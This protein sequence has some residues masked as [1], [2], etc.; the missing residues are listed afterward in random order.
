[1]GNG[2]NWTRLSLNRFST[3]PSAEPEQKVDVAVDGN[4]KMRPIPIATHQR[5]GPDE[6]RAR[7]QMLVLTLVLIASPLVY[8]WARTRD[9][10][11]VVTVDEPVFLTISANFANAIA[12]GDFKETSQ[13]LYPAVPIMWAGTIGFLIGAPNYT[14]DHP[15]QVEPL[16][17]VRAP[18]RSAGYEPLKVLN[19][20][21]E[22]KIIVQACVFLIGLWLIYRLFGIAVTALASAFIIF[23]PFLIAHD[24]LLHVDG[25]T[26][27]TA[28]VSMLA[29][30]NADR[31]RA[32]K[33]WALASVMAALCWLTRLTGLVLL[34]I[35]LLVIA[36]RA[37]TDYR[38]NKLTRREAFA[39]VVKTSGFM[40]S[41]S[42]LTTIIVWPAL[43][44]DPIGAIRET[45]GKW[46][47]SVETPHP[48]GLFF[49]GET[50]TG[51]PGI[52][53][54]VYVFLYKMTPFTL[55]GLS[56]TVFALLHYVRSII[57]HRSWR[58][59]LILST[60]VVVYSVGMVAGE[61]KFDRYVL[62][63]FLFFDLFAAM[64][65]VGVARLLWAQ[66]AS[67]WRIGTT[68]VVVGLVAGQMVSALTQRPY[69]L[70]YFNPLMGGA[71]S[72]E[73][74]IMLGWGEGF[75]QAANYILSQPGG[76]TATVLVS[77]RSSTLAYYLPE[78]ATV[79]NIL[80]IEPNQESILEWANSDYAVIHILQWQR[81]TSGRFV[82]YFDDKT[83]AHT[84]A[85]DGVPF[86]KVYDLG[87]TPPP[88]W[89]ISES[90]CSWRFDDQ[91]TL[92]SYGQ[93]QPEAGETL[94]PNEQMIDIIFQTNNSVELETA[95]ELDGVL[96]PREGEDGDVFFS[97]TFVPNP[98][99]GMLSKA[100]QTV[101]LPEGK[102]LSDYWLRIAVTNPKTGEQLKALNLT[103][104]T[105]SDNAGQPSC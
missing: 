13:F 11:R 54:Y 49:Q 69:A 66:P 72:A 7:W 91:I 30:A 70:D 31:D 25:F 79:R 105:T 90:T 48:W 75:D 34:P 82:H 52:L 98:Q 104:G 41:I 67:V 8:A 28:F 45:I 92:A 99:N 55:A 97:T 74:T 63:D 16:D 83:P 22:V 9:L 60:F 84:V 10:D 73:D 42:I 76:D 102:T 93:H 51:D 86:V 80:G 4:G 23:D 56:V 24:Q 36:V 35:F 40:L 6:C 71:K 47:H 101:Q 29:A 19:E 20:A 44:V 61:R 50:V 43:W 57:P 77:T 62:P 2:G 27:I 14:K 26:G 15:E 33:W 1:M 39:S 103:N 94:A 38:A 100:V 58:P 65:F 59:V 87:V 12:H 64:G 78:T 95:Y 17:A 68:I 53:Y 37:A 5:T 18:L 89:M 85:I 21:R 88:T 46:R 3:V 32:K 81:E 96:I